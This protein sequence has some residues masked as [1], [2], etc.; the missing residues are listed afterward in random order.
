VRDRTARDSDLLAAELRADPVLAPGATEPPYSGFSTYTLYPDPGGPFRRI[1]TI[2][3]QTLRGTVWRPTPTMERLAA[4]ATDLLDVERLAAGAWVD[5]AWMPWE[6]DVRFLFLAARA[7]GQPWPTPDVAT[8]SPL[9]GDLALLA[10]S[11]PSPLNAWPETR[12]ARMT[13]SAGEALLGTL[14]P[15]TVPSAANRPAFVRVLLGDAARGRAL[16]VMF[17]TPMPDEVAGGCSAPTLA[18]VW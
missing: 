13:T 18:W 1:S 2:D 15:G 17:V 6:P 9:D 10:D 5:P 12:C 8:G 4:L 3:P 11:V 7:S 14:P 16:M